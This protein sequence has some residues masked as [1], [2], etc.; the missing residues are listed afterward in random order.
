M[1]SWQQRI[2]YGTGTMTLPYKTW[3]LDALPNPI[4]NMALVPRA[5][6]VGSEKTITYGERANGQRR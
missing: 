1:E 3:F 6:H 5:D 4:D 2:S